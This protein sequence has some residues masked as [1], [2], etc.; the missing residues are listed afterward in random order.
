MEPIK[1][2]LV[3]VG[4]MI[5]SGIVIIIIW[6]MV[7]SVKQVRTASLLVVGVIKQRSPLLGGALEGLVK[8]FVWF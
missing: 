2:L 1:F 4:I 5:V 6:D 8:T 7:F 3:L